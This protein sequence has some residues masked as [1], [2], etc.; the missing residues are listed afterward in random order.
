MR[1][2]LRFILHYFSLA[3]IALLPDWLFYPGISLPGGFFSALVSVQEGQTII[4]KGRTGTSATRPTRG[5]LLS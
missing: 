3:G 2:R 1:N 5:Q 4:R